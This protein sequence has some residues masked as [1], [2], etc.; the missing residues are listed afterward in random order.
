MSNYINSVQLLG[1][2]GKEPEKRTMQNGKDVFS[3]SLCTAEGWKDKQSG[4]WV[5][6]TEWHKIVIFN[7]NLIAKAEKKL[8]KG[9]LVQVI[10]KLQTRKWTDKE[11]RD[12]Y[13]TEIVLDGP[14]AELFP[15]SRLKG[16]SGEEVD[17]T[18]N[19]DDNVIGDEALPL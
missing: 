4:E 9:S 17:N 19:F 16:A 2:I 14:K 6:K 13:T 5:E 1:N 7:P 18:E 10:G 11:G 3:F 8:Q 12:N 15:L